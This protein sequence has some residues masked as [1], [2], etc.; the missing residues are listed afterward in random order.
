MNK[1]LARDKIFKNNF[2]LYNNYIMSIK[3]E[4]LN[5]FSCNICNKNYKTQTNLLKHKQSHINKPNSENSCEVKI[6]KG[7]I[8]KKCNQVFNSQPTKW[9]HEKNCLGKDT[10]EDVTKLKNEIKEIKSQLTK[11]ADKPNI[12]NNNYTQNNNNVVITNPPGLETI[13]H[14]SLDQKRFIMNKG[15]SSLMYLI[16]TTNFNKQK[17]ENHCYC[18]TAINDKHASMIDHKTNSVIKTDKMELYDKVLAG[19]L[20]KLEKLSADTE[21]KS[22]EKLKYVNDVDRLKKILFVSKKGIKKYYSEIN[23][24][25]YNNKDLVQDT[26]NSLKKLDELVITNKINSSNI[27]NYKVSVNEESDEGKSDSS[28]IESDE[29]IN[30]EKLIK[31]RKQFGV[32]IIPDSYSDSDLSS[33]DDSDTEECGLIEINVNGKQYILDGTQ[34]YTKSL[35]GTKGELYGIYLNGKIKKSKQP[36]EFNI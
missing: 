23:L 8:C 11:L 31:L 13:E 22:E 15:L 30:T 1:N 7:L 32:N 12:I 18:V 17:P 33:D 34:V 9:R 3:S 14:L 26:W 27:I 20:N 10:N 36:K 35:S 5:L 19:N 25:S 6:K 4:N 21:F 29:E 2:I 16:E 28:D 24:L